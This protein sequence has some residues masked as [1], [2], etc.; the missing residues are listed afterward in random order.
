MYAP[1]LTTVRPDTLQAMLA[2]LEVNAEDIVATLLATEESGSPVGHAALRLT[3]DRL[4][5]KKVFVHA[6][7]RGRRV[8]RALMAEVETIARERRHP[9]LV[10]QTGH[11]QSPAMALYESLGYYRVDPFPP[12]GAIPGEVCYRKDLE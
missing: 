9:V 1:G 11:L 4:E 12:Y 10:L 6:S 2:S 5:V 7:H 8:A 3:R